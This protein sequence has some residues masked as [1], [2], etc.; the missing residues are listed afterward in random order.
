MFLRNEAWKSDCKQRIF[1]SGSTLKNPT[2][3]VC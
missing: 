3:G 2:V 1:E